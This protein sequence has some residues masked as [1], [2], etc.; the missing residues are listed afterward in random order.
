MN[1]GCLRP[2]YVQRRR[3]ALSVKCFRCAAVGHRETHGRGLG[4]C[5]ANVRP[6]ARAWQAASL[7]FHIL[8]VDFFLSFFFL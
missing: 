3:T 5:V 4:N 2:I 7:R 6:K 1:L 8:H